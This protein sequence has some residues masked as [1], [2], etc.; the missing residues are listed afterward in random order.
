MNLR[1]FVKLINAYCWELQQFCNDLIPELVHRIRT[2][3]QSSGEEHLRKYVRAQ[4]HLVILF[5]DT[6]FRIPDMGNS[7]RDAL[8]SLIQDIEAINLGNVPKPPEEI[9]NFLENK[10]PSFYF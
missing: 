1:E 5:H 7:V 8:K 9:E 3:D 6:D 10:L 2:E 4:G